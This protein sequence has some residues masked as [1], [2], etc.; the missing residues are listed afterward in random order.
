MINIIIIMMI[1]IIIVLINT[2]GYDFSCVLAIAFPIFPNN[3][4]LKGIP[5]GASSGACVGKS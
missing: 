1:I 5:H 3:A 2:Y 4:S